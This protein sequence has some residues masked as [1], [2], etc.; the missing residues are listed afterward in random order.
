MGASRHRRF[1]PDDLELEKAG[2]LDVDLQVGPLRDTSGSAHR[3]V[4]PD[5]ELGL[6]LTSNVELDVSGAFSAD[7]SSG[8]RRFSGEALWI[9]SKLE[10][11][12][13]HDRAGNA[14]AVGLELGPRLPTLGSEGIGY[15]ALGLLGYKGRRI[16]LV[17]NA[18]TLF[19][20]GA[21]P[22]AT[23]SGS[24]LFGLDLNVELSPSGRW[25]A[26][27][28]L[29]F[30]HYLGADPD[31]LEATLGGTYAVSKTL[32]ASLTLLAGAA[33]AAQHAGLL[34]GL[35]PQFQIW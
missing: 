14:F 15:G 18:G 16:G 13:D 11:F 34:L 33:A 10:L 12:D 9:A 8:A 24:L 35:S 28:E 31:E 22:H 32:D 1:E 5:F 25:S 19:D 7:S 6:G 26:Q 17:L 21:S 29:G 4:L 23:P 30:T 3:V 2:T 27:S 20:P